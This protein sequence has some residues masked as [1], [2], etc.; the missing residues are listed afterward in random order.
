[1]QIISHNRAS[2][3]SI[4]HVAGAKLE[5][6]TESYTTTIWEVF[7]DKWEIRAIIERAPGDRI[8]FQTIVDPLPN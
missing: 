6:R 8:V 2:D 3:S 5:A 1:M 4:F 7:G